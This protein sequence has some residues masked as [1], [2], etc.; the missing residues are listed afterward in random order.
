[1]HL[2]YIPN[3]VTSLGQECFKNCNENLIIFLGHNSTNPSGFSSGN[4][5]YYPWYG[6][7][8]LRVCD[9]EEFIEEE[10]YIFSHNIDDTITICEYLGRDTD[11]V[12]PE[13]INDMNVTEIACNVFK[14]QNRIKT[15][16]FPNTLTKIYSNA[17]DGCSALTSMILPSSL[18]T[19]MGEAFAN[20][21]ALTKLI[22]PTNIKN[23]GINAFNGCP[24]LEL[25]V[26]S[27]T[28]PSGFEVGRYSYDPD[29]NSGVKMTYYGV[30]NGWFLDEQG[31]PYHL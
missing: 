18:V 13:K 25:Y 28:R 24:N 22:I 5:G 4:Y 10:N 11:L 17:F 21:S 16:V 6:S 1:M 2:A 7:A 31:N 12:L 26:E 8:K 3:S 30:G 23:I 14:N 27:A 19:I 9:C 15:I 20:C 29:W